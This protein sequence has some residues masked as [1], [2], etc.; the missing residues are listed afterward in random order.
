MSFNMF[1]FNVL[2]VVYHGCLYLKSSLFLPFLSCNVHFHGF[3]TVSINGHDEF[4]SSRLKHGHQIHRRVT[5][6]T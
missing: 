6:D 4:W 1:R 5:N 2:V 3:S